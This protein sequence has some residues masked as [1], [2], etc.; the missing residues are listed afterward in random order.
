MRL[1]INRE[2]WIRGPNQRS[3]LI[4]E[5]DEKMC[6]LGFLGLACGISSKELEGRSRPADVNDRSD[7]LWP[8]LAQPAI[9]GCRRDSELVD[10]L[11]NVNDGKFSEYNREAQI[12]NLMEQ[13]GVK[14]EFIG[15]DDVEST[16]DEEDGR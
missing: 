13:L 9:D 6:C 11:I 8:L 3:F 2:M 15:G 5:I 12:T 1:I 7:D 14:V 16:G 4:R 10:E